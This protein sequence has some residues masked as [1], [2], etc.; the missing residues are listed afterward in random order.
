MK[1]IGIDVEATGAALGI[2]SMLAF[3]VAV[4]DTD[5]L[6]VVEKRRWLIRETPAPRWEFRCLREFWFASGAEAGKVLLAECDM[7]G[8]SPKGAMDHFVAWCSKQV[9]RFGVESLQFVTDNAAFDAAWISY[10]LAAHTPVQ[11][12]HYALGEYRSVVDT[13][14]FHG[15]VARLHPDTS[16]WGLTDAARARLGVPAPTKSLSHLPD[17]DAA[18][19]ALAHATILKHM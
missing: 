8:Q 18:D 16:V 6:E 7:Y 13:S 15:G 9:A 3:G 14:S 5:T 11:S 10:Y 4:V 1:L 19:I 2:H 12:L 17:D